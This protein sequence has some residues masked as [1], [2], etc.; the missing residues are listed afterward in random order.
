MGPQI[1]ANFHGGNRPSKTL[2]K[3]E[4]RRILYFYD[5]SWRQMVDVK[6]MEIPGIYFQDQNTEQW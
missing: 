4:S 1:Q 5:V 3:D 6:R 2:C